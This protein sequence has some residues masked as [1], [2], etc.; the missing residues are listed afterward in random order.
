MLTMAWVEL[1]TIS[2][3]INFLQGERAAARAKD[4]HRRAGELTAELAEAMSLRA[5]LVA[6]IGELLGAGAD[7]AAPPNGMLAAA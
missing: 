7:S 3:Q 1:T 4:D 6:R 5:R 2:T